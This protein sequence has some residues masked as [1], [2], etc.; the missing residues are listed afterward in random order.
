MARG[1]LMKKLLASYGRDDEFKAV[2]EQIIVEEEK[3][4]N[5]VLARALRRTLENSTT[6]KYAEQPKNLTPLTPFPDVAND[7]IERI[8]PDHAHKEIMLSFENVVIFKGLIQEYRFSA[9]IQRHGLPVRSKLL[10]CG[11]PGCGKTLCAEVFS[12][13]LGLPLFVVKLDKLI[14]SY[15]GETAT[16]IRKIFEF[17]R[18]QACVLFLDE[19]DAIA[20]SRDD[21]NEHNELRRVVNSLLLFIDRINP[22]GFMIAA[23]NLDSSIDPAI[24][25]RFDE[26]IWFQ[27]PSLALIKRYLKTK[28]KN[29]K[30]DFEP[31]DYAGML[32]GFSYSEIERVCNQAIK[33]SIIKRN[34]IITEEYFTSA[35]EDG[36]RRKAGR[37][38]IF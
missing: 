20:R 18:K 9:E 35:I 25:R 14:S 2:A 34:K 26:V 13:E 19:F 8:D 22:K 37:V 28:F 5:R 30:L 38:D 11:P 27:K 29:V 31:Q 21:S 16:N 12:S 4:N 24:W 3:K 15:L 1:E 32:D 23:T 36:N 6:A 10:F 7:F 17:A 33:T